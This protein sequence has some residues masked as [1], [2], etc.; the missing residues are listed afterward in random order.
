MGSLNPSRD[1]EGAER[2]GRL[3]TRAALKRRAEAGFLQTRVAG[4]K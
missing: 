1:R 2:A 3:L 4:E